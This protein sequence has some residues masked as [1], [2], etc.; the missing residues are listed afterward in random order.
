MGSS[1]DR[2][3]ES[4]RECRRAD[5]Q[6]RLQQLA[7]SAV[8]SRPDLFRVALASAI[9][10]AYPQ[11]H[12]VRAAV[13]VALTRQ[14]RDMRAPQLERGALLVPSGRSVVDARDARPSRAAD[15]VDQRL[16]DMRLDA[17]IIQPVTN[18]RRRSCSRHAGSASRSPWQ[19]AGQAAICSSTTR[20]TGRHL[21]RTATRAP[22]YRPPHRWQQCDRHRRQDQFVRR[23]FCCARTAAPKSPFRRAPPSSAR[24]SACRQLPGSGTG[25]YQQ[26]HDATV[27]RR[28]AD[29]APYRH[30]LVVAQYALARALRAGLSVKAT[31]WRRD[32][33]IPQANSADKLPRTR[34]AATGAR[35]AMSSSKLAI[36]RCVTLYIH[37]VSSRIS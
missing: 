30:K 6:P 14:L 16:Y 7:L 1:N 29:A 34:F 23:R 31:G 27:V 28:A 5:P 36:I 19:R 22:V 20:R 13:G 21:R 15:M 8:F 35:F 3:G 18:V 9:H 11:R 4:H 12:D 33:F 25:Q 26:P 17:K 24:T 10:S 37:F 2:P 32:P